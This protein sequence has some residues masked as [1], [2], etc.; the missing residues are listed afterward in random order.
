M[1][2][3]VNYMILLNS[4]DD[5]F[6]DMNILA[7]AIEAIIFI[8]GEPISLERLC[9]IFNIIPKKKDKRKGGVN[10]A[11]PDNPLVAKKKKEMILKAVDLIK[12]KFNEGS[13]HGIYLS[14]NNDSYSFKTKPEYYRVISEFL[15]VKPQ[16]FTKPQLE[17]LSI[18]AYKQ[19]VI[20]SEVD[21]VRGV[22]SGG[23]ITFLLEKNLIKV[24]GRKDII[25]K[26]LIYKTTDHFLEVF[27]L[28]N[29]GDLPSVK[30]IEDVI[31]K[32]ERT[33]K[34]A[35]EGAESREHGGADGL[36]FY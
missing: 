18:I 3:K 30:E 6:E 12:D 17:T 11:G 10:P 32:R 15:K 8:S 1:E 28:K 35:E 5:Y 24:S 25:G 29:L 19:P 33:D 13:V 2:D 4:L 16:K 20:K 14:I 27:N 9:K 23:V 34:P 36:L 26:P 31:E 21:T 7:P 22:D